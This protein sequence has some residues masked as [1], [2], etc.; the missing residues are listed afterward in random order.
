MSCII[1][2][3]NEAIY[4]SAEFYRDYVSETLAETCKAVWQSLKDDDNDIRD[5]VTGFIEKEAAKYADSKPTLAIYLYSVCLAIAPKPY[6][7]EAGIDILLSKPDYFTKNNLHFYAYQYQCAAFKCKEADSLEVKLK[8]W[9]LFKVVYEYF[10]AEVTAD[11]T[12][13]PMDSRNKN[14][15]VVIT[16][17]MLS[18]GHGPTKTTLD[19]C[20]TLITRYNKEVLLIT[21]NEMLTNCGELPFFDQRVGNK[22]VAFADKE[23]FEWKGVS[24]PQLYLNYEMPDVNIINEM[25]VYIRKL[26]PSRIVVI[27]GMS[28]LANLADKMIPA[29]DVGLSPSELEPSC[30][31]YQT[32]GKKL[33]E[34]ELYLMEKIGLPKEH[35]VE[36]I[37][38]SGLKEQEG[39]M[40]RSLFG[41]PEN[42][43]VM[44]VIGGR[45]YEEV[46]KE[47]LNMLESIWQDDFFI[48][49]LGRFSHNE[50]VLPKFEKISK[51]YHIDRVEDILAALELCDLYVNPIRRGGG[52]SCVEAMFKGVPVVTTAYGDVPANTGEEFIVADY[53]E[54]GDT[55]TRYY[56]DIDFYREKSAIAK[57]RAEILLDTDGEFVRIMD[58][59]ERRER[60]NK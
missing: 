29:I 41:I 48:L 27:G 50:E 28:I 57:K 13:I 1:E 37:F 17:Q 23:A 55:I 4:Q 7:I 19:R 58:E 30:V 20:K 40:E 52:T 38:T 18:E 22:N 39:T 53:K 5:E 54:M 47:F 24:V 59:V 42:A 3:L 10:E 15:V 26:A 35:A 6:H 11:L 49:F 46:D 25:L 8:I 60:E 36:C 51:A 45:L 56:N 43:F 34:N 21:T 14:L 2:V 16:E 44:T 31:R 33:E 32:L 12:P 9:Q